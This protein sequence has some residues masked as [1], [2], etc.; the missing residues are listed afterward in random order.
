MTS[1]FHCQY[2]SFMR[3]STNIGH[4]PIQAYSILQQ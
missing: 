2:I 3:F 4:L 1:Y